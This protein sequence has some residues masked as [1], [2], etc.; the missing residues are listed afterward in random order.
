MDLRPLARSVAGSGRG[1]HVSLHGVSGELHPATA[2]GSI[3]DVASLDGSTTDQTALKNALR[4]GRQ[5]EIRDRTAEGQHYRMADLNLLVAIII[6]WGTAHL[7]RA[8][9]ERQNAGLACP[10]NLLAKLAPR[11]GTSC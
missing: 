2:L 9:A 7:G 1:N 6:Y 4:I 8:V 11:L 5:G 3:S 10:P